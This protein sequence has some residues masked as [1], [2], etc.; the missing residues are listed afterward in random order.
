MRKYFD[1]FFV[2]DLLSQTPML[3]G[4]FVTSDSSYSLIVFQF[5]LEWLIF[6]QYRSLQRVYA[7]VERALMENP[8]VA[9]YLPI[10]NLYL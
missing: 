8:T 3:L 9:M 6:L 5:I 10:V 1:Q 2:R 7:R 4:Y